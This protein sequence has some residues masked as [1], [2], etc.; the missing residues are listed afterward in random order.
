[1][2]SCMCVGFFFCILVCNPLPV[3]LTNHLLLSNLINSFFR[4]INSLPFPFSCAFHFASSFLFLLRCHSSGVRVFIFV[5][6]TSEFMANV[7][8]RRGRSRYTYRKPGQAHSIN[9][10]NYCAGNMVAYTHQQKRK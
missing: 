8:C 1:V 9:L 2:S 5:M 10:I 7:S 4:M 6:P 3:G